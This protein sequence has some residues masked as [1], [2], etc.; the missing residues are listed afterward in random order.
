VIE[1]DG[2][3]MAAMDRLIVDAVK[4]TVSDIHKQLEEWG[5]TNNNNL[6]QPQRQHQTAVSGATMSSTAEDGS[7]E[8]F[9]YLN[10][11]NMALKCYGGS[12]GWTADLPPEISMGLYDLSRQL[13]KGT[14]GNRPREIVIR[15]QTGDYWLVGRQGGERELYAVIARKDSTMND[16]EELLRQFSQQSLCNILMC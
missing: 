10:K 7:I 14:R 9:L 5:A 4:P 2:Q 11:V 15:T 8:R 3:L 13:R 16:V 6:S 1:E 12:A